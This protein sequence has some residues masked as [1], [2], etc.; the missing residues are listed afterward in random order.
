LPK[1]CELLQVTGVEL[2]GGGGI[3]EYLV[4]QRHLSKYRVVVYQGR[5]CDRIIFLS[6]I[7]ILQR[8]TL[9]Y[10][11][12]Y[13]HVITKLMATMNKR[14][15]CPACN[16]SCVRGDRL[17]CDA[18]SEAYWVI[19]PCI[20]GNSGIPCDECSRHFGNVA[21]YENHKRLKISNKPECRAK[22]LCPSVVSYL[23][24]VTSPTY[25][26]FT[27]SEEEGLCAQKL[28]ESSF[29]QGTT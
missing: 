10:D 26:L 7:S 21:G 20:T 14:Y 23:G 15:V 19:T 1:F 8:I 5:R 4:F 25:V 11:G 2:S 17:K 12:Q 9:L 22:K 29:G 24:R 28:Q 3:P 18:S 13:Y 16:K 27:L 6:Q